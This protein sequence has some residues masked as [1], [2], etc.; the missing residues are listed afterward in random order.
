MQRGD[1]LN[2]PRIKGNVSVHLPCLDTREL[3]NSS[4]AAKPLERT[5]FAVADRTLWGQPDMADFSGKSRCSFIKVPVQN[6][7]GTHSG[8]GCEENHITGT[9]SRSIMPFSQRPGIGIVHQEGFPAKTRLKHGANGNVCPI[10][11]IGRPLDNPVFTIQ[12]AAA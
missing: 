3:R 9:P 8:P 6:Q 5:S 11:Q 1:S 4:S 7:T 10:W 2:R 12:R